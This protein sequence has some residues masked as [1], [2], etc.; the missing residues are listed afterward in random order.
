MDWIQQLVEKDQ[1]L[2]LYLNSLGTPQWDSFWLF[3]TNKFSWIPLYIMLL[4]VVFR[5]YNWKGLLI[6]LLGAALLVATTDQITNLFKNVLVMRLRPC[7]E[8]E[9]AALVRVVKG[10]CGGKYGFFSGHASNHFAVAVYLG[11]ILRKY[12]YVLPSLLIWAGFIAY[13]RIYVGVHYPLDISVGAMAGS[14]LGYGFYQLWNYVM[15]KF[16]LKN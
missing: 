9:V 11:L 7:Y 8:P 14:L 16:I 6:T 15:S 13:S 2:F 4:Y 3:V 10:S 5:K 1:E 12:K